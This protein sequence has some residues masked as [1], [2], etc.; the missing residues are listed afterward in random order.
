[1]KERVLL[2]M[3]T[4]LMSRFQIGDEVAVN[5]G[6][7]GVVLGKVVGVIFTKKQVFYNIVVFP[8]P[9][10]EE[11]TFVLLEKIHAFYVEAPLARFY[12][13]SVIELKLPEN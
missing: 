13:A 4:P 12:N 6:S 7:A 1:M 10:D 5:F 3:P 8:F 9:E 2:C 11:E